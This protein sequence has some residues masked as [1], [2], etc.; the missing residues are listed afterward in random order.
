MDS[1]KNDDQGRSAAA[2]EIKKALREPS[3]TYVG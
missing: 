2:I 3:G 1:L